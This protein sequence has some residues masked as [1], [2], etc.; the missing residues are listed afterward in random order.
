MMKEGLGADV[1]LDRMDNNNGDENPYRDLT[2]NNTERVE[3]SHSSMEQW[4]ILSNVINY[5]QHSK[6]PKNFHFTTI[7]LAKLNKMVNDKDKNES[8]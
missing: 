3:M 1:E 8:L 7:K 6:K 5:A 2:V 4:A